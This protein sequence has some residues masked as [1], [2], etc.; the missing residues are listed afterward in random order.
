[1][2]RRTRTTLALSAAAVVVAVAVAVLAFD[3][4]GRPAT[5]P[6]R[7]GGGD[8]AAM[9]EAASPV[10]DV[11]A[12]AMIG[13]GVTYEVPDDLPALDGD[14]AAYRLA[15]PTEDE[16]A[17]LAAA[18][19]ID[20]DVTSAN[21]MLRVTA[22][23]RVLE[24]MDHPGAPWSY[25]ETVVAEDGGGASGSSGSA[26][27]GSSGSEEEGA[28]GTTTDSE[29][30]TVVPVDGAQPVEPPAEPLVDEAT[31][32]QVGRAVAEAAGIDLDGAT[33]AVDAAAPDRVVRVDPAVDG[34]PTFGMTTYV[35]V[36]EGGRITWANGTLGAVEEADTYPLVGTAVAADQLG[37]GIP[38]GPVALGGDDES[39][40]SGV[41]T[42]VPVDEAS[43]EEGATTDQEVV[44]VAGEPAAG[45]GC[46]PELGPDGDAATRDACPAGATVE[47]APAPCDDTVGDTAGMCAAPCDPK[48]G[49]DGNALTDDGCP[50][51]GPT[52]CDP[53]TGPDG[54]P[55]TED[56]CLPPDVPACD[57]ATGAD[58]DA[59]TE[60][61]CPPDDCV[62]TAD[63]ASSC[64]VDP[65]PLPEPEPVVARVNGVRLGLALVPSADGTG[66]W[67]LPAYLWETE[68]VG[69]EVPS[70]EVTL[71]IA[72]EYLLPATAGDGD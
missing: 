49:P 10:D 56:T 58:G 12:P 61:G 52:G 17:R 25:Y 13:P 34:L 1:M 63:P 27:S 57:P 23:D 21:G 20:G 60:D 37:T 16:V 31:A 4:G 65:V 62:D 44:E 39:V 70:I 6:V 67:L 18:L 35:G 8:D 47:P 38:G 41:V 32:E 11:A 46:D 72:D 22:G 45:A 53:A 19:R 42:A 9:T 28:S 2:T 24:V 69:S 14:A 54:D 66:S 36:G 68:Y 3:G 5:L 30:V 7:A 15:R 33:V 29:V 51:P 48:T 55:A 43:T 40:S 59:A 50:E 26:G 64:L 71:A